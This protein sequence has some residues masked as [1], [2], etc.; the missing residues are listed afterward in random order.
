MPT[1]GFTAAVSV[2]KG[3][4]PKKPFE[5]MVPGFRSAIYSGLSK[6]STLASFGRIWPVLA[7]IGPGFGRAPGIGW[8]DGFIIGLVPG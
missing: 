5:F 7:R 3:T 4:P 8:D 2:F 6:A 1:R